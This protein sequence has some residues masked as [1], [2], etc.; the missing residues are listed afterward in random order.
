MQHNCQS[1]AV[2]T[3]KISLAIGTESLI[4]GVFKYRGL[5]SIVNTKPD[6]VAA[7]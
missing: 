2:S 5:N 3:V 6:P 4:H 1:L 7:N